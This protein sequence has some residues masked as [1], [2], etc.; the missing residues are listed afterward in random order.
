MIVFNIT[1]FIIGGVSLMISMTVGYALGW[2]NFEEVRLSP[3]PEYAVVLGAGLL[4]VMD[5]AW[6]LRNIRTLNTPPPPTIIMRG[7]PIATRP[8]PVMNT[9]KMFLSGEK[10]AQF[11]WVIPG[12]VVGLLGLSS[13]FV[14]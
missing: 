13:A 1:A 12:W 8:Q 3:H 9:L 2:I 7:G 11:F 4:S 14:K 10:G 6:R 5:L